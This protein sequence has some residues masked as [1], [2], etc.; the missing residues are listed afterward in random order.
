MI[1]ELLRRRVPQIFGLYLIGAWGLIQ[2]VDWA[3]Q[4]YVLSPHITN[5]VVALLLLMIPSVV[6]LAYRYGQPGDDTWTRVEKIAVPLNV[7]AAAGILYFGFAGKD[8]G[9]ATTTVLLEDDAG[10]EIE[11]EV[12]KQEFRK[13][14]A[15][16]YFDNESGDKSLDWLSYGVT[17]GLQTDLSQ[18]LFV[19][20]AS[21]LSSEGLSSILL[22][23]QEA[24]FANG[25]GVPLTLM[26]KIADQRHF[27]FFI[28][29]A[30]LRGEA[31]LELQSRLYETRRGK[32]LQRRTF[33]GGDALELID[34]IS[35]QLRRDLGVPEYRLEESPDLPVSELLTSSL[36]AFEDAAM[37]FHTIAG[38]DVEGSVSLLERSVEADPTFAL[39]QA[40]LAAVYMLSNRSSEAD[41]AMQMAT[42]HL[43]R[44]PERSRLA[45]RTL[46]QWLFKQDADKAFSTA[47]YWAEL[48][49]D[50]I[51]A[52]LTL[53]QI[54]N[55]KGERA[56][57]IGEYETILQ[58]DPSQFDY[59]RRI[60]GLYADGGE[61]ERALD[62][63]NRY[64]ELF[65]DDWRSYTGIAR[66]HRSMGDFDQAR[67]A[68]ERAGVVD[69]DEPSIPISLGQLE[70]DNGNFEQAAAYR[71]QALAA[72]KSPQDRFAVYGLDELLHGRQGQFD[73]LE[74]DYRR[75]SEEAAEFMNPVN[76]VI[77]R[78]NSDFLQFAA[79]AGREESALRELD[80]LSAGI[81]PPFDGLTAIAYLQIYQT[82]EDKE[83]V[84]AQIERLNA[85][86]EALGFEALRPVVSLGEGR[87]AEIDGD[88]P[89]AIDNYRKM[90][91]SNPNL[92]TPLLR[93][94][95]CQ[96]SL[97]EA[98]EAEG[99]L[100]GVLRLV[101]AHP[102]ARYQLALVY[103]EMGR[104]DDA[105][106]QLD[107]ALEV[108]KNADLEYKPAQ[109]ARELRARL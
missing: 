43:Y 38:G 109:R 18:D 12:P 6:L 99:T 24:G 31:G 1:H 107:A 35:E 19:S 23:L 3:V 68:Y 47:Q 61:F 60:G 14:V 72:S 26:R 104:T 102:Y 13:K 77:N 89:V 100:L 40:Q 67:M 22:D 83:Q 56:L 17:L 69:P 94:A 11:R 41:S 79:D 2:F 80:R 51:Q 52:H 7:I 90:I 85:V 34:Q 101:P 91:E 97:G 103:E 84:Q 76:L 32:L 4:Q 57:E 64:A 37:A 58:L 39:S 9:A 75:R 33:T 28:A 71:E 96:L 74:Q 36:P 65:P 30:I 46:D 10:N 42:R 92:R 45:L 108:W 63:Y 70:V 21:P 106:E 81:S 86:I 66:T 5:F 53:A 95:G 27:D 82:L 62:Y 105:T 87:I 78:A 16:F 49:P 54:Y 98:A 50:D 29:G 15:V 48:Y 59:I 55:S 73:E 8:L 44:L 25:V 93:I 88:C 20:T